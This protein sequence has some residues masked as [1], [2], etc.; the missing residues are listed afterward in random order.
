MDPITTELA[1]S[2]EPEDFFE[3]LTS[4]A[5]ASGNATFEAGEVV[6]VLSAP[7]QV[8]HEEVK[9]L[10]V[11]IRASMRARQ[12]LTG[13]RFSLVGPR[14]THHDSEGRR[15]H[16]M[17]AGTGRLEMTGFP[18]DI[19][20][21]NATGVIVHDMRTSRITEETFI[22]R[23]FAQ[24]ASASPTL[25]RML[26]SYGRS[27]EDPANAL[28]YLYEIRDAVSAHLG[29]DTA[30]RKR[31]QIS[32]ADWH[33]LGNLANDEPVAEGRHRG[34]KESLR[35]ATNEEIT[36]ARTI[37]RRLIQLFADHACR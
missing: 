35:A 18:V 16:V 19:R 26:D 29:G 7:Q 11:Q 30:A 20:I 10:D 1:Y 34:K 9:K 2:Y 5:L 13:K 14:I 27:L 24:K 28:I 36:E 17:L 37:G 32:R 3:A 12:L 22:F 31:L 33:T 6:F 4:V 23:T 21:T 25:R 15:H 8:G